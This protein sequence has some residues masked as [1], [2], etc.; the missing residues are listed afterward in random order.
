MNRVRSL[1]RIR[2]MLPGYSLERKPNVP[3]LV[4]ISVFHVTVGLIITIGFIT[5]RMLAL[6]KLV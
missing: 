3:D 1:L 5:K 2:C 6:E 4:A